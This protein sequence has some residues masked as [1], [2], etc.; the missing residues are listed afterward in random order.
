MRTDKEIINSLELA[1]WGIFHEEY[2]HSPDFIKP[3]ILGIKTGFHD[4]DNKRLKDKCIKDWR[5]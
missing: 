1:L 2:S 4:A 3:A 5:E